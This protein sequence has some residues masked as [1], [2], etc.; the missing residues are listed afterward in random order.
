M[1]RPC[2]L[3]V[4]FLSSLSH[5][6]TAQISDAILNAR[7]SAQWITRPGPPVNLFSAAADPGLQEYGVYNFRKSFA[8]STK[9]ESFIVHVSGDNRY[10]LFVNGKYV[11]Q[12][13][14]R[15][16]LYFWNYETVDL[17]P[18]LVAGNNTLA[19]VV[20][21]DG[22]FKPAAQ[23]S[24]ATGFI[25]QGNTSREE[26]A[27]TNDSWKVIRDEGY[28]P[29][30][31]RAPGYYVAGP[32]ELVDM[33]QRVKGWTLPGYD[34]SP[35]AN[36]RPIGRGTPKAASVNSTGWML[37]PSPIPQ[38][39]MTLQ[40]L[41]ATRKAE[42]VHVPPAFPAEKTTVTIPAHTRATLVLDN[43]V[44]TN[45]YPTLVFSGGR[46]AAISLGYAEAFYVHNGEDISRDWLPELPKGNRNEIEG[47]IFLGK[48]DSII[49]DGSA[50]Q[51]YTPLWWRT[52]RYIVLIVDTR[53]EALD[54]EDLYGTFTGY[55]FRQNASLKTSDPE[56]GSMMEIGWRTARL[57]AFETYMDCPYYE[58][59]QYIGDARIQ[60]LVSY[61]NAGDD[62]LARNGITLM[63]H[64]RLAEGITLS[65]Y[66]TALKQEIPTFSLWWIAMVHDFYRYRPDTVFVKDRL[67]GTRQVLSFFEN[68]Q[69]PDG[70]L[71]NVP[72]W[73]FTDWVEHEGWDFGMAPKGRNGESAV[74]DLTLL[75]TYQLAAELERD[76]GVKEIARD[77]TERARQLQQA[78]RSKYWDEGSGLF[79]DT[80][81]KNLFSQHV[82][83][84]AILSGVVMG[85]EATALAKKL[86]TDTTLA[87]AS[88]YFKYYL[89]RALTKAG[90]GDNYLQWL[91]VWRQNMAMG[92]TTWAETSD[93]GRARSDCH[94]W[95]S[96]PN[97]EF[98]RT[99]L[100]IDSDA[101]GFARVK[102]TPHLGAIKAISGA[103]P[104]PN[105]KISVKYNVSGEG[106]R[107]EVVLP[108]NT[109]GYLEWR[110][111]R[112]ALKEGRN[113]LRI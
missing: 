112:Y 70:S 78:I 21:N 29:L 23:I 84:L 76:L 67:P 7:W 93:V 68:Y 40:R 63:D 99:V 4:V 47:K 102:I 32:G 19:A 6:A 89:H 64:S 58:Q 69:Q 9:P 82:N 97:V 88:I 61:Y 41:S 38:M 30:R 90:L 94:A 65:R 22:P 46:D 14:A 108:D 105:G 17:A 62:R 27:N 49:S 35:W 79:A 57:C 59:L 18:F 3:L 52:Y 50:S 113:F 42:G 33:R 24:Y 107:A 71:K 92:L 51:R 100:G 28:R 12:G 101:P 103:M 25:L 54:I 91:E 44:L 83:S 110:G 73:V 77:Y 5:H 20:W 87:P 43:G 104:H 34:D 56:P 39:E 36:A 13:P 86:V 85:D 98:F 106:F 96:S 95:G 66:P 16:D 48:R 111:K 11:S 81:A 75:R 15:G 37:V 53:K 80:E 60:A 74:L 8:L 109:E 55:P 2:I 10:Q 26:V 1:Q 45:A 31:V 72:Y